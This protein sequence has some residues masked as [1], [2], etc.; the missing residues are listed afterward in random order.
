MRPMTTALALSLALAACGPKTPVE[1]MLKPGDARE[2]PGALPERAFTMPP[3]ATA[4]LSNGLEVK[5][6]TNAEV[7]L[8]EV[9]LLVK[10][11]SF[12]DPDA[13]EGLASVTFDMA[14]EGAADRSAEDISRA[15]KLLGGSVGVGAGLNSGSITASGAKRNLEGILDVWADVLLRPTFPGADWTLMQERRIADLIASQ[16]DPSAIS[17]R[18]LSRVMW[19]NTY[20]GRHTSE[21]AYSAITTDDMKALWKKTVAP[22]NAVLLVGGDLTLEEIV[23]LMEARLA[24]WKPTEMRLRSPVAQAAEIE[25]ATVYLVDKPG[26]AQSVV[27]VA[28]PIGSRLDSDYFDLMMGNTVFGGAFTAR[29]NMNLREDKGYTYGARCRTSYRN[30]PGIWSC[31]ANINTPVTG[32]ALTEIKN[33]LAGIVGDTKVTADELAYF[34]SYRVNGFYGRYETSGSL[35]SEQTNLWLYDLPADW[36]E[37]YIPGVQGVELEAANAAFAK[38]IDPDKLVWLIV[39]DAATIRGDLDALGLPVVEL[40]RE[41]NRLEAP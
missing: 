26:A 36:L 33:E 11:G 31:G 17:G 22:D 13:K 28:T 37:R 9:R 3:V 18:A 24:E 27:S 29:L 4:T 16:E 30:G 5:V 40:D 23:P 1:T 15:L 2:R 21:L 34:Q 39:G 8:W 35:L 6:A 38:S 20:A 14:N 32:L 10:T 7:P 19:G 25:A 41:G 12:A